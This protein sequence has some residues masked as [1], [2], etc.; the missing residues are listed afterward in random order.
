MSIHQLN[1]YGRDKVQ[2]A[3]ERFKT[4][5]PMAGEKHLQICQGSSMRHTT[6]ILP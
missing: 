6:R 4:F 5:E 3:I 1:I 2:V